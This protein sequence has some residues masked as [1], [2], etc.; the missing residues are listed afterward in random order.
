M[1]QTWRT[2]IG[3]TSGPGERRRRG[4]SDFEFVLLQL[5]KQ[6]IQFGEEDRSDLE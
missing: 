2:R 6:E 3:G 5:R 1:G 4:A